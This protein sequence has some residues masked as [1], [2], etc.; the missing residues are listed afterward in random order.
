MKRNCCE[1]K[2]ITPEAHVPFERV[3]LPVQTIVPG[4]F[5]CGQENPSGIKLRFYQEGPKTVSTSFTPPDD[6]TGWGKVMHGGFHGV[7]L[8]EAMAWASFGLM[9]EKGF[10]TKEMTIKYIRP[11]YVGWPVIVYGH[12]VEDRGRE[13]I[14]RGEIKDETGNLLTEGSSILIRVDPE[15]LKR[16]DK[17]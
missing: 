8:D 11:V 7:L 14:V 16:A 10:V 3:L 5:G 13:I 9:N 15:S 12:I 1:V 2:A 17:N 6:W 4:C